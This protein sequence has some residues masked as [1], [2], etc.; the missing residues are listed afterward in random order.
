MDHLICIIGPD[1]TGK[2]TQANLLIDSL[3]KKGIN[4]EYRWLR[5]HHFFSL[6]ILGLARLL[7]LS[8]IKI[9][10]NGEKVGYHYFYKSKLISRLYSIS[11]FV[12][13][14]IFT[15]VKVYIPMKLFN[16]NIAC[17]RFIYDTLIDL[18]ISTGNSN[19]YKS[20]LGNLFLR[21]IPKNN[22]S[23]MLIA[24]ENV[25]KARRD[26][27]NYDKNLNS[28]INLYKKLAQKFE[29]PVINAELPI[30]E[31]NLQIMRVINE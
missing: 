2:S 27:V 24:D 22:K 25:L 13:T 8:E 5:F 1:G 16:R 6:P 28:K 26:D 4:C 14:F 12:D 15:I 3:K 11:L 10:K 9:L 17:D 29:I 19:I 21:L 31:I 18:M 30:T 20:T 7:G 23:L